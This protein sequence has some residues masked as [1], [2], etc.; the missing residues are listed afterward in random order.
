MTWM[1]DYATRAQV[2][3]Y[4]RVE[5]DADDA[6]IDTWITAVSR[7]VDQFCGRQF[8]QVAALEA[9]TYEV[10]HDRHVPTYFAYV[11]DVQDVT[12]IEVMTSYGDVLSASD[13]ALLPRNAAATGRPYEEIKL[14]SFTCEI[15]VTAKWG[16]NAVPAAVT[17]GLFLQAARLAARRDSP[18]GISGSPSE[19]GEIRL[20]A[21]LDPDFRT[22]LRPLQRPWWAA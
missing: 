2:K 19:Q 21:Q 7:N 15:T 22:V 10:I 18:F 11:D 1:P 20:L 6:L 9:R 3:R 12:G 5:D 13:Y 17:E 4:L 14:T 16:W 8:G